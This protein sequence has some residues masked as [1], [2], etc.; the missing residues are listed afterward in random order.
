MKAIE[1]LE[2]KIRRLY[3]EAEAL[4]YGNQYEYREA[5]RR[6][7]NAQIEYLEAMANREMRF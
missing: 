4:R 5:R 1:T 2:Q 3:D 6:F 7:L